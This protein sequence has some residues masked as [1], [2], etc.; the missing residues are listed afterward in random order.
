MTT[1]NAP[2]IPDEFICPITMEL[3]LYPMA[4]RHGPNN[5][6]RDAIISWLARGNR[7]CPLTRTPL[8]IGDL[9]HNNYLTAQIQA[10]R[11]QHG[12]E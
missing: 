10:R 3:M 6:E 5:F 11:Q 9:I 2:T 4:T 1:T 12:V 7:H 8:K